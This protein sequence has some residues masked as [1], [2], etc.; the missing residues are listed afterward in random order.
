MFEQLGEH[1]K[2]ALGV[3]NPEA[4]RSTDP[5]AH[6]EGVEGV[7]SS[8]SL[9][10]EHWV[11]VAKNFREAIE[12]LKSRIG[13]YFTVVFSGKTEQRPKNQYG[14][15]DQ[16]DQNLQS[17]NLKNQSNQESN[18]KP[19]SDRGANQGRSKMTRRQFLRFTVTGAGLILAGYF[20]RMPLAGLLD[21]LVFPP[22]KLVKISLS[23]LL[24]S[25]LN[26]TPRAIGRPADEI[27]DY[28]AKKFADPNKNE[29]RKIEQ[30]LF[31]NPFWPKEYILPN[32]SKI[33]SGV[34][35]E[36]PSNS[37]PLE[38]HPDLPKEK[39]S[40]G[41]NSNSFKIG[42][43]LKIAGFDI[44]TDARG[45]WKGQQEYCAI[46]VDQQNNYLAIGYEGGLYGYDFEQRNGVG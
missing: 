7:D 41:S 11:L 19:S 42:E 20:Y 29:V 22:E 16:T 10:S 33:F 27:S 17:E 12:R 15:P 24:Q 40:S 13:F 31:A 35:L 46:F 14:V 34:F 26:S 38:L 28:F 18:Q 44:I 36:K 4:P 21:E 3:K 45:L 9:N 5:T 43:H 1:V 37:Q 2:E 25:T 8:V 6:S 39:G 23:E 32:P 30:F